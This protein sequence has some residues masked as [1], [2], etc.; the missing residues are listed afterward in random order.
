MEKILLIG[1][2]AA[3]SLGISYGIFNYSSKYS[4]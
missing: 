1:G 3:T 2:I 4:K